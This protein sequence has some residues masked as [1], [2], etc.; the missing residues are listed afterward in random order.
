M[1]KTCF[2]IFKWL[3]V[4]IVAISL[5]VLINSIDNGEYNDSALLSQM[6]RVQDADNGYTHISYLSQEDYELLTEEQRQSLREHLNDEIWN[7]K[8]VVAILAEQSELF[9]DVERALAKPYFQFPE[10]KSVADINIPSNFYTVW[11]LYEL[12]SRYE[13]KNGEINLAFNSLETGVNFSEKVRS[14]LNGSLLSYYIALNMHAEALHWA[15]EMASGGQLSEQQYETLLEAISG[16]ESYGNDGIAHIPTG[17]YQYDKMIMLEIFAASDEMSFSERIEDFRDEQQHWDNYVA[18]YGKEPGGERP[19]LYAFAT[20]I[21]PKYY[22]NPGKTLPEISQYYL[23][24]QTYANKYCQEHESLKTDMVKWGRE[25][26]WSDLFMPNS[27]GVQFQEYRADWRFHFRR[28]CFFH[29]YNDGVN[30]AIALQWYKRQHG[31]YPNELIELVPDFLEAVPRDY[32]T[33]EDLM[34]SKESAWLYSAGANYTDDGGQF[35]GNFFG[36]CKENDPCY[37]NPTIPITIEY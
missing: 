34:Y 30:T 36:K 25:A 23:Q 27:A 7:E 31:Y 33:G 10:I 26:H 15:H 2:K 19:G 20:A 14:E 32:F 22:F 11:R 29:V 13:F 9:K 1:L 3:T 28:V 24:I 8:V 4:F 6:V 5:W 16:I 18:E 21:L 12:K 37:I 17:E 35:D